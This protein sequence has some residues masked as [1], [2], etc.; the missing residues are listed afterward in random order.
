MDVSTLPATSV[1][2]DSSTPTLPV[3]ESLTTE[4]ASVSSVCSHVAALL[5]LFSSAP[6][7]FD[8]SKARLPC[9][10]M[11]Y[12][13][14]EFLFYRHSTVG[15]IV[16]SFV[17]FTPELPPVRDAVVLSNRAPD[18]TH[19]GSLS[20]SVVSFLAKDP[21]AANSFLRSE[22]SSTFLA[23]D[24]ALSAILTETLFMAPK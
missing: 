24:V 6:D 18:F 12:V 23:I 8:F 15:T 21:M 11:R 3:A 13:G 16:F 10:P 2:R 20:T 7:S 5:T 1:S 14:G 4:R 22:Y 17:T 19:R 9:F